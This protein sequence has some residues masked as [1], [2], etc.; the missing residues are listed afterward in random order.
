[1]ARGIAKR[2]RA[3]PKPPARVE[4]LEELAVACDAGALAPPGGASGSA[5]AASIRALDRFVGATSVKRLVRDM[6]LLSCLGLADPE[7]FTNVMITGS[8]GTG[9][10]ELLALVSEILLAL[11]HGKRAKVTWLTRASLV[12]Q[13]LG[14]TALKTARA[15]ASAAPGVIV[16]DEVYALGSGDGRDSFAKECVDTLNQFMSECRDLVS[17]V[18]AGY[19]HETEQCFLHQNPGLA[20]RFPHRFH[21]DDYTT[22]ELCAIA[23]RQL[24]RAEWKA[25][26][27]FART[28]CFRA[29][30]AKSKFNGG[31]TAR[32]LT[33][34]KLAHARR[35]PSAAELRVLTVADVAC[36]CAEFVATTER[37]EE[38]VLG[39]YL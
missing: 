28:E 21:V 7:D 19:K 9:K 36:A 15:L 29:A 11:Y 30:L 4:T 8:P 39:M 16:L 2:T 34:C 24:E 33:M 35:I 23:E 17:V 6:A 32:L 14:E 26:D 10:T 20:R 38:T 13:H 31:D 27:G 18:V 5:L 12:G 22:D 37:K 1:M 3:R 25:F